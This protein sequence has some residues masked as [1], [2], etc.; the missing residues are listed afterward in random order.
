MN[1][2]QFV[3]DLKTASYRDKGQ[4]L[5]YLLR[6]A[7]RKLKTLSKEDRQL[8][9]SY[10]FGEVDAMLRV[11]PETVS[12]REKDVIFHCED[13]VL[14]LIMKLCGTPD[15]LRREQL[16][17]IQSL[18]DLVDKERYIENTV[19]SLF[20]NPSVSETDMN[21]LL[22]WVKQ[23]TDEYQK[24]M[25]FQGLLHHKEKLKK[26][27]PPARQLLEEYVISEATRLKE[28]ST[29]DSGAVLELIADVGKH[30]P[31]GSMIAAL[32]GLLTLDKNP[33]SYY[34]VESLLTLNRDVPQGVI[35]ALAE[36]L[37]YADLTYSVLRRMG[38]TSLFPKE[39][40]TDEYLGKSDLVHW[41]TYPTELG[42]APDEILYVGKVKRF[43]ST[44]VFHVYRFRSD[45]DTLSDDLKNKWLIGWSS[46][47][48]GTF[49]NFEEYAGF[50]GPTAKETLNR[51]K[52]HILG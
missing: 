37:E 16:S 2:F 29:E 38:K 15:Q 44:K 47:E 20:Q 45:S 3:N 41:L 22:Y 51:I 27:S 10:A 34:A 49:S 25:L 23:T 26:L 4:L 7:E 52:K 6:V 30:F 32:E 50:E 8:L 35:T 14:G 19:D 24:S 13:C 33:I 21:R 12:Y 48:G 11:I 39:Y 5:Q 1:V 28:L 43:F 18:V 17:K 31:T 40:A 42:K 46:E 9:L 36:D